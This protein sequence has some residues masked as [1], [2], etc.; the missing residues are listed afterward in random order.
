MALLST[1]WVTS[2]AAAG[3]AKTFTNSIGIEFV[4][5]PA[6]S[7]MVGADKHFEDASDNETFRIKAK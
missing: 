1:F 3:P 5:I 7:F 6:G 4:L 2:P